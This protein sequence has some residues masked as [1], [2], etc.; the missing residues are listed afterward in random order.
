[1]F[2]YNLFPFFASMILLIIIVLAIGV[3]FYRNALI[4]FVVIPVAMFSAFTG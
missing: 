4:M 3:H 2:D 1:M